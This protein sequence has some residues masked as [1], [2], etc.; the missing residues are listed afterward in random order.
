[1]DTRTKIVEAG[2]VPAHCTV[3]TGTFDVMLAQDA[4]ELAE[5]RAQYPSQAVCVV[6]LPLAQE[7]LSQRARAELAAALRMVDYVVIADNPAPH[8]I[9]AALHPG[10]IVPLEAA[11]ELRKRH[12]TEHVRSRQTR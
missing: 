2:L 12:L 5:I 11:H 1:M 8:A 3:I 6:V 4:K 9:L 10:R 7:L